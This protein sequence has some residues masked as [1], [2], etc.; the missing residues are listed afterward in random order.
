MLSVEAVG[1]PQV[2]AVN[3]ALTCK[4]AAFLTSSVD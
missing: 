3:G 1:S 4:E 2:F